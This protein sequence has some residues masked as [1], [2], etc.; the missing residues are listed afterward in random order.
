MPGAD[1]LVNIEGLPFVDYLWTLWSPKFK[2]DKH[3]RS[4]KE[5]LSS[6]GTMTATLKYYVGLTDALRTGRLQMNEMHTPTL[7]IYGST[8]STARYSVAI[9]PLFKGPY[10]NIGLPD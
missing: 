5:T 3:L 1:S 10:K 9:E 6:P 2:N 8:D 7:T 4:I